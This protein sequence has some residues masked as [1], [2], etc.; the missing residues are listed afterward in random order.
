[1]GDKFR[2]LEI[3]RGRLL[4]LEAGRLQSASNAAIRPYSLIGLQG[5]GYRR[6]GGGSIIML[7][8]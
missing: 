1:M 5:C 2:G 7:N 4:A 3:R 6:E 8:Q